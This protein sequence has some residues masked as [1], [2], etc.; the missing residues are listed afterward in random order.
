MASGSSTAKYLIVTVYPNDM[1]ATSPTDGFVIVFSSSS[2]N[3]TLTTGWAAPSQ[4]A[5]AVLPDTEIKAQFIKLTS[6]VVLCGLSL[7]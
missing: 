4:P 3:S 7:F 5:A 6:L 2:W 1:T